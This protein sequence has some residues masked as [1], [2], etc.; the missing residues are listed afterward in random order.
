[1]PRT[2]ADLAERI[3]ER[4][5]RE[6]PIPF[7]R[8][9][10]AALYDEDGGFYTR[11]GGAGR[12]G[13]DFVTSPE[14]GVLF[15]AL[16][17]RYL[18]RA[19]AE[20]ARP[21]P[22]VVVDAGAGRGRLAAD[23]LRAG[24]ECSRALRYVL[25]E[26]SAALR[27]AQRELLR[28]EPADRAFGPAVRD[29]PDEAPRPVEDVGPI[30]T[31]LPEFP[32]LELA[33]GV[34]IANELL[35]NLPFRLVERARAGWTEVRVGLAPDGFAE[36]SV[37]ASPEIAAAAGDVAARA[38][39][40]E[41]ARLPVPTATVDW[42]DKCAHVLRRGFLVVIDYADDAASLAARRQDEWLRTY[43]GHER[44]ETPLAAP[45]AQDITSTV[46]AEYLVAHATRAGF[47]LVEH[48]TQ[49]EWL[50]ALGIEELVDDAR[51]LWRE[52]AGVGDLEALAARS[53]VIEAAALTDPSGLGTHHVFVFA[54]G[55]RSD[56]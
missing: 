2:D 32:A 38:T 18:D 20:L 10:E 11:G 52:R 12:A 55:L 13:R 44:G 31:S 43:R 28:L 15:G 24:P 16:V 3:T 56:R 39:I 35:D 21:D 9:V 53:R 5:R 46:P 40:P 23:V 14:V 30:A 41:R 37:P 4:I 50:G 36:V 27:V 6:G 17:A 47:R 33:A 51:G 22:F 7:D 49:A 54:K 8:F 48:T 19:W 34:V 25:A 1:M 29:D 42:L 26:R 45:G